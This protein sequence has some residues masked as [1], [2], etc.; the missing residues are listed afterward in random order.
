LTNA[1]TSAVLRPSRLSSVT[2]RVSVS[3]SICSNS[4]IRRCLRR[5]REVFGRY[6]FRPRDGF[7]KGSWSHFRRQTPSPQ[8]W[9]L[10]SQ[11]LP[12][13]L[14]LEGQHRLSGPL[15]LQLKP[16]GTQTRQPGGGAHES[17]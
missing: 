17:P 2:I 9:L 15:S 5:W 12:N 8:M 16:Q 6:L 4:S 14:F 13:D 10:G 1:T 11:Q 3:F 7:D